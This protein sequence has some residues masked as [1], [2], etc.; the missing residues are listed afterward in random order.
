MKDFTVPTHSLAAQVWFTDGRTMTGTL[1]LPLAESGGSRGPL[2]AW[3]K[4]APAFAP[5]RTAASNVVI[6]SRATLAAV[7]TPRVPSDGLPDEDRAGV[8]YGVEVETQGGFVFRGQLRI[9]MPRERQRVTDWFNAEDEYVVLATDDQRVLLQKAHILR[10]H[11]T[12][13]RSSQ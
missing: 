7:A 1:F 4:H 3:A 8:T 13:E 12:G 6:V 10:V 9:A 5:L 11:E 2:E